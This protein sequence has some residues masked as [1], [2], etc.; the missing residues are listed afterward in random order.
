MTTACRRTCTQLTYTFADQQYDSAKTISISQHSLLRGRDDCRQ[1]RAVHELL[2]QSTAGTAQVQTTP[3]QILQF[4]TE[5]YIAGQASATLTSIDTIN[6]QAQT[7]FTDTGGFVN[8]D[9]NG[10]ILPQQFQLITYNNLVY[11]IRAVTNV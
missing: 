2:H 9:S 4:P 6:T 7:A 5:C 1:C 8:Q 10:N 11:M 3:N